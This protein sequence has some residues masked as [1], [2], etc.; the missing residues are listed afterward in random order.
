METTYKVV[1]T[2]KDGQRVPV[3]SFE[4]LGEA[5]RLV[6]ALSGYWPNDYAILNGNGAEHDLIGTGGG[7]AEETESPISFD[8]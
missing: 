5:R 7:H 2:L 4:A 6:A 1:C 3:A 8:G